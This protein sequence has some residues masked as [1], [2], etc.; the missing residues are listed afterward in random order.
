MAAP[1]VLLG[2]VLRPEVDPEG[3]NAVHQLRLGIAEHGVIHEVGLHLLF[4][5]KALSSLDGGK[6]PGTD[7]VRPVSEPVDH[8]LGVE[9]FGHPTIVQGRFPRY[10]RLWPALHCRHMVDGGC[11]GPVGCVGRRLGRGQS[12]DKE[13]R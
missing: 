2:G 9:S 1:S 6:A 4:E 13:F 12:G 8:G 3:E 10:D 11:P 5:A 7:G